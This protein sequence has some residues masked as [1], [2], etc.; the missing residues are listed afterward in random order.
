MSDSHETQEKG[1]WFANGLR[2]AAY[3]VDL[4]L[5]LGL[6][7]AGLEPECICEYVFRKLKFI[8][9]CFKKM[10]LWIRKATHCSF[11]SS[12]FPASTGSGML[13]RRLEVRVQLVD[14][15]KFFYCVNS[16]E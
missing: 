12:F 14:L 3:A 10:E 8:G 13:G 5:W 6:L 15:L 2:F 7:G 11:T 4:I 16:A 9:L 1:V